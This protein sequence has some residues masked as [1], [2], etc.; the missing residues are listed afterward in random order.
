M[1]SLY[2][3]LSGAH[4]VWSVPHTSHSVLVAVWHGGHAVN[5]YKVTATRN[6]LEVVPHDTAGIGDYKT[7]ETTREQARSAAAGIMGYPEESL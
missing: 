4:G 2:D 7:G 5:S 3:T 6:G 1:A